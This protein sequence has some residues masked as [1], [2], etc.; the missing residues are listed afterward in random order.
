MLLKMCLRNIGSFRECLG[1]VRE[2]DGD[3]GVYFFLKNF[4]FHYVGQG[5]FWFC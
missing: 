1:A 4:Y 5:G 3:V 2:G